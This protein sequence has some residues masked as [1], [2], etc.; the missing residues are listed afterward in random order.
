MRN[1]TI[2]VLCLLVIYYLHLY[3]VTLFHDTIDINMAETLNDVKIEIIRTELYIKTLEKRVNAI[4]KSSIEKHKAD[5]AS[6]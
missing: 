3:V 5:A 2:T 4:E 6:H 1:V